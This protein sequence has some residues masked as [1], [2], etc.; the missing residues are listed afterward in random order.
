[1]LR[2]YDEY[3]ATGVIVDNDQLASFSWAAKPAP[4][5]FGWK[6]NVPGVIV[7]SLYDCATPYV[8][9]RWMRASFPGA[10]LMTWQGIGHC[11]STAKYDPEGVKSCNAQMGRYMMTGVPPLDGFV[12]RSHVLF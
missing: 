7:G 9:T 5:Q 1:M 3:A 4:A 6:E 10:S 8:N 11:V 2:Q 12:C